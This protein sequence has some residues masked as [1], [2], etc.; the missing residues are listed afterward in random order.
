MNFYNSIIFLLFLNVALGLAQKSSLESTYY[1]LFDS[2]IG[3]ENTN[4]YK[5]TVYTSKYRSINEFTPRLYFDY[6]DGSILYD[7]QWYF[8][9][10]IN[11]NVYDDLILMRL[12]M[13]SRN[14]LVQPLQQ[15]VECFR[16][17]DRFFVHI[18]WEELKGFYE[19]L[20]QFEDLDL[21]L[22]R[23]LR[24]NRNDKNNKVYEYSE[25]NDRKPIYY[26]KYDGKYYNL[27]SY[28]ILKQLFPQLSEVIVQGH[29]ESRNLSKVDVAAYYSRLLQIIYKNISIHS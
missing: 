15:Q 14:V 21:G 4:L 19:Q 20:V 7:G 24:K 29:K 9:V 18:D 17:E 10:S 3:P 6:I 16:L 22:Y 27:K 5:G 28:K 26:L 23:K 8:R 2:N 25:F 13:A 12:P 1:E 11:Y